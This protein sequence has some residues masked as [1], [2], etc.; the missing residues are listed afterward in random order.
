MPASDS[1]FAHMQI[2]FIIESTELSQRH[3][4][5]YYTAKHM[6]RFLSHTSTSANEASADVKN[7][8]CHFISAIMRFC[9]GVFE[10]VITEH[11]LFFTSHFPGRNP[12]KK[13][14][15]GFRKSN[16]E[17]L[18]DLRRKV[19]TFELPLKIQR[20]ALVPAVVVI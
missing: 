7:E 17:A 13:Q 20:S 10:C 2:V 6:S 15:Y 8:D 19:P 5:C 4:R 11:L 12:N 18:S 1:A 16:L 3:P 14:S 9:F